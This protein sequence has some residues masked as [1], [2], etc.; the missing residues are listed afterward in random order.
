MREALVATVEGAAV[1]GALIV[2]WALLC[3]VRPLIGAYLA[4][5]ALRP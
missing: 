4:L 3:D 5:R 1:A 2:L